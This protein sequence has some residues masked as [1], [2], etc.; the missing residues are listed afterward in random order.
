MY[1]W[2]PIL[3][4]ISLKNS[5]GGVFFQFVANF[6]M[7]RNK[8]QSFGRHFETVNFLGYFL[9]EYGYFNV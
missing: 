2:S 3:S 4:Q 1:S 7:K 6:E 8:N 5:F 9:L